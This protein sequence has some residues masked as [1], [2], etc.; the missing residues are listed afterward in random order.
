MLKVTSNKLGKII[1]LVKWHLTISLKNRG[2]MFFGQMPMLEYIYL[3]PGC[4]QNDIAN[5]M[6]FSR[7]AISKGISKLITKDLVVREVSPVDSR[8]YRLYLTGQ[9]EC[10]FQSFKN[11]FD[12]VEELAY[13]GISSADIEHLENILDKMLM[14]L[15]VENY[16]KRNLEKLIEDYKEV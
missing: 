12:E 2:E 6:C 4:N 3:H 15:E 9:G 13:R 16:S 11:C 10:A 1:N 8:E 7:A 5:V 14:N